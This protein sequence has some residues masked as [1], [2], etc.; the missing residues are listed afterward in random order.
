MPNL[1]DCCEGAG[2]VHTSGPLS[3]TLRVCTQWEHTLFPHKYISLSFFLCL[4]QASLKTKQQLQSYYK[5][6]SGTASGQYFY[7]K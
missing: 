7:P 4:E 5:V 3:L 1:Q 2:D 6:D